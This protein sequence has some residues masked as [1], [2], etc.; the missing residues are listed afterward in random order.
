MVN[1]AEK[2]KA[3]DD[4]AVA[5]VQAKNAFKTYVYNLRNLINEE[6]LADM[7]DPADKSNS[8]STVSE[9]IS[10]L[11]ASPEASGDEYESRQKELEGLGS[12]PS[13]RS[14]LTT[15]ETHET[16]AATLDPPDPW[17]VGMGSW[18]DAVHASF[19]NYFLMSLTGFVQLCYLSV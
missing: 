14:R 10:W 17:V 13:C 2:Y 18:W 11:D 9:A 5:R 1:E 4:A 3:E 19:D 8:K 12:P 15:H 6:K 16:H 7:F